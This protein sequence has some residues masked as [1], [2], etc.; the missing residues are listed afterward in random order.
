M[1]SSKC[2]RFYFLVFY[3]YLFVSN[4][5]NAQTII[6]EKIE[7]KVSLSPY[8]GVALFPS[9]LNFN[10]LGVA[11]NLFEGIAP[12]P[13]AGIAAWYKYKKRVFFGVDG[14][15]LYTF[16]NVSPLNA[17]GI[18]ALGKM[19][20]LNAK[21]RINPFVQA[22]FNVSFVNM[23]RK[24]QVINTFIDSLGGFKVDKN[25][26][27]LNKLDLY[28]APMAGPVVGAGF[29]VKINRK[30]SAFVQANV[31]TSFGR[32]GLIQDAFPSNNSVLRYAS[33][34]G[35]VNMKLFKSMR[36]EIDTSMVKVQDAV[37][38]LNPEEISAEPQ[39]MLSREGNF[40]VNLREGLRHNLKLAVHDGE[41]NIELDNKEGPCKT[42]AILYDQFGNKVASTMADENGNINFTNLEK[43]EFNVLF[44]VQ[45]P[46]P[47][48]SNLAYKINSPGTEIISQGNEEY[49]PMSDSLAYNIEGFVNFKDPAIATRGIDVLLVNQDDKMVKSRM[50]TAQDGQFTFRNLKPG[51]YKVVYEVGNPKIQSKM[52]YS[53]KD[54]KDKV[55]K[56]EDIPFND[57]TTKPKEGTRLMSGKLELND[58]AVAAYKLNLDLV[59]KYNRV[60]DH[61]IAND[62]GSF[63]F[64]DRKSDNSDVIFEIGDKKLE[65]KLAIAE[66][67]GK[68]APLVKSLVYQPRMDAKSAIAAAN[69]GKEGVTLKSVVPIEGMEMYKLY[70]RNGGITTIAGFGY[71][72]GAFRNMDNVYN[73]MDKLKADGFDAFVQTVMSNDVASKFKAST[74]YKLHRIIV[75]GTGDDM[76]ANEI[77]AKLQA[78][79]YPIIVK[80]QFKP[81]NIYKAEGEK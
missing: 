8:L 3:F 42:M 63:G 40:D 28:F 47:Q 74:N 18:S 2:K 50:K 31:Q 64:L 13:V 73:L 43:G 45:P 29:D 37:V 39:Q 52:A 26:V 30:F 36:F 6:T 68:A 75:F 4:F 32:S 66:A 70:D 27:G 72:V 48:S 53:V 9:Q 69:V 76:V 65:Q 54:N 21:Y 71:Q 10:E 78:Q 12:S 80:E 61:S 49:T 67:E 56:S 79:G 41:L 59:D 77:K 38:M 22:G 55:I 14:N 58:P 17:V 24:A 46:C 62:D 81:V 35:G 44:E 23:N 1:L 11:G 19:Y 34:R 7:R 51:N 33:I 25:E 16:N 20:L 57:I 60:V 5:C 15:F